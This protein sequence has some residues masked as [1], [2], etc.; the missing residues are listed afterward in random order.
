MRFIALALAL[1]CIQFTTR[2]VLA[3]AATESERARAVRLEKENAEL[4]VRVAAL[5]SELA[6]LK[7]KGAPESQPASR[8]VETGD[9]RGARWGMSPDDV[10]AVEKGRFGTA[11][12]TDRGG[13]A[14]Y[15]Q[16]TVA[17]FEVM[18]GY[19]FYENKLVR[20][21]LLPAVSHTAPNLYVE[22]FNRLRDALKNKYGQPDAGGTHWK[23]DILKGQSGGLG[24]SVVAGY[25]EMES[26]WEKLPRT[27]ILLKLTG[28][29]YKAKLIVFYDSKEHRGLFDKARTRKDQ[30]D[31]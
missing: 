16:D 11:S 12:T 2:A 18:V 26:R 7:G 14:L 30:A 31:F 4:K 13:T 24:L 5:E 29:N 19:L 21:V 6:G 28:D 20:V 10:R 3:Q 15:F 9:V 23:N 25:A 22:D 27:E 1:A 17:G 8:P